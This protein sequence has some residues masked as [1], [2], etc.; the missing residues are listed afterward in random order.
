MSEPI[1]VLADGV[2]SHSDREVSEVVTLNVRHNGTIAGATLRNGRMSYEPAAHVAN[3]RANT[4]STT[5][6]VSRGGNVRTS[7]GRPG[8]VRDGARADAG[9]KVEVVSNAHI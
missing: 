9:G 7:S 3:A 4:Y 1:R 8:D 5:G 6:L 2:C